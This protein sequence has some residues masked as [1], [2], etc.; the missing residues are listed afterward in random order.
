[1]GIERPT[2]VK[3]ESLEPEELAARLRESAGR[4]SPNR[5]MDDLELRHLVR[6]VHE[7]SVLLKDVY[8]DRRIARIME[9]DRLVDRLVQRFMDR[10]P[11]IAGQDRSLHPRLPADVR[12]L[13]D[14]ALFD[15]GLLRLPR[16]QG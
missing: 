15:S 16:L 12:R 8:T 2:G 7:C 13:A 6:V 14:Q 1:M 3:I 4:V 11:A 10:E 9:P 5:V